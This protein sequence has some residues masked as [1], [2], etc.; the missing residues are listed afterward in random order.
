MRFIFL[1]FAQIVVLFSNAQQN[2]IINWSQSYRL[3]Y[4]DFQ[5]TVPG[6]A[7]KAIQGT[8]DASIELNFEQVGDVVNVSLVSYFKRHDSWI[9]TEAKNEYT[10]KHEQ[11]HFDIAEIFAR[12]M[13]KALQKKKLDRRNGASQIKKIFN[14]L[15]KKYLETQ[16][17]YDNA[18]G[19]SIKVK[20]QEKWIQKISDELKELEAYKE[21]TLVMRFK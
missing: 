16:K 18:T 3:T 4:E 13:R 10:L 21:T 7:N 5:A 11:G 1:F 12:K 8:T 15:L 17:E 9:R 2:N 14:K 19:H 6:N 20:D